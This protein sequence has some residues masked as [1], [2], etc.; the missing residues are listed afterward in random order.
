MNETNDQARLAAKAII[1]K[2]TT[3]IRDRRGLGD[4]WEQISP[5][6]MD[7]ELIP[8]WTKII[9]KEIAKASDQQ[10]EAAPT[11]EAIAG[12]LKQPGSTSG[13][14]YQPPSE[15]DLEI[16]SLRCTLYQAASRYH[17]CLL[18]EGHT[19]DEIMRFSDEL[20]NAADAWAMR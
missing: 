20:E 10:P 3:D 15:R 1:E 9:E 16:Q 6:V 14:E 2:L 4:E 11:A 7:E 17:E 13:D 18:R 12:S 8:A 19:L 5:S